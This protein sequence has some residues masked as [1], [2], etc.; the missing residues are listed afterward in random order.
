MCISAQFSF[1]AYISALSGCTVLWRKKFRAEAIFYFVV[2]QMQLVE[3]VLHLTSSPLL[4]LH[5]PLLASPPSSAFLLT[6]PHTC[7]GTLTQTQRAGNLIATNTGIV[8]NHLEPLALWIGIEYEQG[9]SYYLT[10]ARHH[11]SDHHHYYRRSI[12]KWMC[13]YMALATIYTASSFTTEITRFSEKGDRL[14]RHKRHLVWA[15]NSS[16]YENDQNN[17]AAIGFY[18]FFLVTLNLL[19]LGLMIPDCR[20]SIHATFVTLSFI[21]AHLISSEGYA[22]SLWCLMASFAPWL[23]LAAYRCFGVVATRVID[24]AG[25]EEKKSQPRSPWHVDDLNCD[26]DDMW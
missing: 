6:S 15:W 2:A 4:P 11:H 1:F 22:G 12:W 13:M 10:V 7:G 23:L 17:L 19:S 26:D 18:G 25:G 16:P 20:G 8:I 14:F 5:P 24:S 3:M 21:V 9:F